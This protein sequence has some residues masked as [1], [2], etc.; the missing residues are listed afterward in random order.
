MRLIPKQVDV[1]DL[2]GYDHKVSGPIARHLV[3]DVDVAALRVVGF[4]SHAAPTLH[5]NGTGRLA[6]RRTLRISRGA[7][8]HAVG[9]MRLFDDFEWPSGYV[10]RHPSMSVYEQGSAARA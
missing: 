9:W 3:R 5:R 6:V 10:P 1:R 4:D 7:A 2:A 8:L